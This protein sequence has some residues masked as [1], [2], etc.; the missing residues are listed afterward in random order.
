MRRLGK[1]GN[2]GR[3]TLK[4][5]ADDSYDT[6]A[7]AVHALLKV[8]TLP[9]CIWE[10]AAGTGSITNI[11]RAAGHIVMSTDIR[12]GVDFLMEY[13][14]PIGCECIVTNPPYKL[15]DKF[16]RHAIDLVP[17]VVMLLRF[18]FLEGVGR[19]DIV[20]RHLARVHLFRNRL[21]MMH[22]KDWAGPR[23]SSM[24]AFAWFVWLRD[25]AGPI[26]LNRVTWE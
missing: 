7:V 4:D 20:D 8:E 11:L 10:P 15:V 23:T 19:S 21:P 12:E 6:P 3:A 5:R 2:P 14:A 18:N 25:H 16:V 26:T 1:T 24:V 9:P 17:M 13:R 22:R